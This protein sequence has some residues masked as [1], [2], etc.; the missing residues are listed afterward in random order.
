MT[1]K[2]LIFINCCLSV[3]CFAQLDNKVE[4]VFNELKDFKYEN[5]QPYYEIEK[6]PSGYIELLIKCLPRKNKMP[7]MSNTEY[8][9]QLKNNNLKDKISAPRIFQKAYIFENYLLIDYYVKHGNYRVTYRVLARFEGKNK[10]DLILIT[11]QNDPSS[12]NGFGTIK[13]DRGHIYVEE[14]II[15]AKDRY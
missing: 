8:L 3:N 10:I 5:S 4:E 1:R 6:V 13:R 2:I 7:L 9:T 11:S 12:R 15:K 14:T